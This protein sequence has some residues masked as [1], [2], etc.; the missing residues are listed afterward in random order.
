MRCPGFVLLFL[1]M[2]VAANAAEPENGVFSR[3]REL[4]TLQIV[5]FDSAG[6]E[7]VK[8]YRLI[9]S[10]VPIPS[11]DTSSFGPRFGSASQL[12][13]VI[14]RQKE[15]SWVA[16]TNRT[17]VFGKDRASLLPLLRL[18]SKDERLEIRPRRHSL[19]IE[20]RMAIR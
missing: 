16:N 7:R 1:W 13:A 2:A 15:I 10:V 4:P 20:W 18:E 5:Q 12:P 6:Q 14:E 3:N 8:P 9:L 11:A 17:D 19:S